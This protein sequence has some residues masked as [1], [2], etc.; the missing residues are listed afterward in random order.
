MTLESAERLVEKIL[1]QLE[2]PYEVSTGA[3]GQHDP[4]GNDDAHGDEEQRTIVVAPEVRE[5]LPEALQP[6]VNTR[7]P[8]PDGSTE[9]S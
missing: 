3:G 5:Q 6:F 4:A 8:R 9:G 7:A 1:Q 2:V